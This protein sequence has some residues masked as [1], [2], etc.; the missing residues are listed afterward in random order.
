MFLR[1]P[2]RPTRAQTSYEGTACDV[3]DFTNTFFNLGATVV[4]ALNIDLFGWN[5]DVE[6][7]NHRV[8]PRIPQLIVARSTVVT[9]FY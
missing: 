5:V 4:H 8:V 9:Q 7:E 6:V 1:L 2:T 3:M